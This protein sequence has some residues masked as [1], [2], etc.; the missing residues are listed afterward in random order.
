MNNKLFLSAVLAACMYCAQPTHSQVVDESVISA[1]QTYSARALAMGG[2]YTAIA[3]EYSALYWNPACLAGL[4]R[5]EMHLSMGYN[6]KQNSASDAVGYSGEKTISQ[7]TLNSIGFAHPFAVSQGSFVFALGYSRTKDFL[8]IL[9]M[10]RK[11]PSNF[12]DAQSDGHLSNW[13]IGLGIDISENISFGGKFSLIT[14]GEDFSQQTLSLK[15]S[16]IDDYFGIGL[17][18]GLQFRLSD[19]IVSGLNIDYTPYLLASRTY[20]E[21][22]D[23]LVYRYTPDTTVF[24]MPLRFTFGLAYTTVPLTVS[25]DVGYKNWQGLKVVVNNESVQYADDLQNTVRVGA[26]VEWILPFFPAKLRIGSGYQQQPYTK[27]KQNSMP[28]YYTGGLGFLVDRVLSIDIGGCYSSIE[29]E[30]AYANTYRLQETMT[31]SRMVLTLAYR[32]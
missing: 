4:R 29:T 16:S 1:D 25:L 9:S 7:I 15:K 5:N 27:I 3:Y 11:N 2:A 31:T 8:D 22:D 28:L 10:T 24:T 32:F 21:E 12:L 17:D 20:T 6:R 26:G 23:S 14:G 19:K 18:A 30:N 13:E